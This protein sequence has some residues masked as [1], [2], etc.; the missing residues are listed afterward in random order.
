M[1]SI[2]TTWLGRLMY[3]CRMGKS[4][5]IYA[6]GNPHSPAHLELNEIIVAWRNY[7]NYCIN[8]LFDKP[9]T[10]NKSTK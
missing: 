6:T 4:A 9:L 1:L 2:D 8:L 3:V 5:R 10:Q 7:K